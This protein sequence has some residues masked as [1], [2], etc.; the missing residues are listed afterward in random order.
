MDKIDVSGISLDG[1]QRFS[2]NSITLSCIDAST[3]FFGCNDILL[4]VWGVAISAEN[5]TISALSEK[6]LTAGYIVEL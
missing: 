3:V 5:C 2:V 6:S 1:D 4:K